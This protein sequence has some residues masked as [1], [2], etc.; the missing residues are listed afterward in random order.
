MAPLF[1]AV[2]AGALGG[3]AHQESPANGPG[4]MPVPAVDAGDAAVVSSLPPRTGPA[5]GPV[6]DLTTMTVSNGLPLA[7]TDTANDVPSSAATDLTDAQ[8]LE[9]THVVNRSV[10]EQSKLAESRGRDAQLKK[11]AATIVRERAQSDIEATALAKAVGLSP[12]QSATSASLEGQAKGTATALKEQEGVDFDR[13]YLD[14]QIREHR[15][16]LDT[17]EQK[18]LPNAKNADLKAYLVGVQA[19]LATD[20]QQAQTLLGKLDVKARTSAIGGM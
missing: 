11:L 4:D 7:D 13:S 16:L 5:Q 20:L 2:A 15:S 9:V 17:L 8:I 3:C 1:V 18:L 12:A 10:I 6:E 14:A 19:T